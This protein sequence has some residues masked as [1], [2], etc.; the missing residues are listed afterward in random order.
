MSG[1]THTPPTVRAGDV[2]RVHVPPLPD[3][4]MVDAVLVGSGTWGYFLRISQRVGGTK[5]SRTIAP[6][7]FEIVSHDNPL[8]T[9]I[10]AIIREMQPSEPLQPSVPV[11]LPT[12]GRVRL[13]I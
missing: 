1:P 8:R 10:R 6:R 9:R 11:E 4:W 5:L 3:L 2:I 13:L 12:L 7:G